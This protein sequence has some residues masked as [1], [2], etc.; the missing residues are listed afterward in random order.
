MPKP[1]TPETD[2]GFSLIEVLVATLLLALLASGVAT[3]LIAA[4]RTV[5]RARAETTAVLA[6]SAR[7]EQ[8][9]GL[10]WGF[11]SAHAPVVGSDGNT[12]LSAR[13][14][15]VGGPGLAASPASA[16]EV[17]APGYVDYLDLHGRWVSNGIGAANA[18]RFVRRWSVQPVPGWPD[19]LVLQ[20]RVVDT[21]RAV[22][23]VHLF[24]LKT[25]TAG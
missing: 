12:D 16:L 24:T 6:A 9:R 14:P 25:R 23:E 18:A 3:L 17:D 21:Q 11:G 20:V 1:I 15:A 13:E 8:L 19:T 7:L 4:T 10:S 22:A 2:A 5:A